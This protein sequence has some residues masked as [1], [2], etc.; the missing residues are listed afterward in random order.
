MPSDGQTAPLV[1]AKLAPCNARSRS[2]WVDSRP[3][4]P[5]ARGS[6]SSTLHHQSGASFSFVMMLTFLFY[7]S[8]IFLLG[9]E[10]FALLPP[11]P[12]PH[13][14]PQPRKIITSEIP[15]DCGWNV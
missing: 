3:P 12:P 6:Y 9:G 15:P 2:L 1:I 4:G 13:V 5:R 10:S 14:P 8:S 11:S 7:L